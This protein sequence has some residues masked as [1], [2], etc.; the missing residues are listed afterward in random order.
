[1]YAMKIFFLVASIIINFITFPMAMLIGTFATDAPDTGLRDFLIGFTFIQGVPIILL[2]T[3][4]YFL[5]K[6]DK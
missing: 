2:G 3:S 1:M 5:L 4:L 6:K